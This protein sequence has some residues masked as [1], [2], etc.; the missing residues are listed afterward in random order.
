MSGKEFDRIM[1]RVLQ[2]K[3]KTRKPKGAKRAAGRKKRGDGK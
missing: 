1:G 2:V 3:P